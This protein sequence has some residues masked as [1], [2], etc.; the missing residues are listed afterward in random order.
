VITLLTTY[1]PDFMRIVTTAALALGLVAACSPSAYVAPNTAHNQNTESIA[2]RIDGVMM[3]AIEDSVFP[4]GVVHILYNGSTVFHKGYGNTDYT[5]QIHVDTST[6]YDLASITKVMSTTLAVMG[7]HHDGLIQLFHPVWYYLPEFN[8]DEKRQIT[9][10]QF[11]THTSGL[12][13]YRTYVDQFQTR[14][15]LYEAMLNEA[16]VYPPGQQYLYSDIGLILTGL[17]IERVTEQRLDH[18]LENTWYRNL[19]LNN[20]MFNPITRHEFNISRVAPT[21]IDTIYRK[22][23]IHSEVHDERSWYMDGVAG[24]AGLFSNS[25]DVGRFTTLLL[26]KG[27]LDGVTY[28][29]SELVR[30]STRRQAPLG[31]RGIGFD[32]KTINGF[33]SAG[34]LASN[35]TYGH[36]G[37]TGTSFWIDPERKLAV[38]ILT[39]RTYPYRGTSTEIARTRAQIGDLAH[40]FSKP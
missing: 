10:Y 20:T 34:N 24:H 25:G 30:N 5:S 14:D 31:R 21:E 28:L 22:K 39:N 2:S 9:I 29:D 35:A 15:K 32:L 11:L 4:G 1:T 13:A 36:T 6:I 16:L 27:Q 18:Y 38:I 17:I 33:S 12:P 19:G 8:T 23:R 40:E 37:F 7:L 3:Q 26:N